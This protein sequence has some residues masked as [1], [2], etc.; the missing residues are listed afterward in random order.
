MDRVAIFFHPFGY[1][2]LTDEILTENS[3]CRSRANRGLPSKSNYEGRI[4]HA[5]DCKAL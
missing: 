5:E 4:Q 1:L 3:R 2:F